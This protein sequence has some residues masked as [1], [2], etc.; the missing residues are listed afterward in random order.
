[1]LITGA[2]LSIQ[3]TVAVILP[4]LPARSSNVNVKSLFPVNIF[5]VAFNPV[6]GSLNPVTIASIF[7]LVHPVPAGIYSILAVGFSVSIVNVHSSLHVLVFPALSI[8]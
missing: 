8:A 4:V 7:W 6:I 2:V 3:E 5:S 1:M